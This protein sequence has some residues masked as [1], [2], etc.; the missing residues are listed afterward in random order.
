MFHIEALADRFATVTTDDTTTGRSS[1]SGASGTTSASLL[2]RVKAQEPAAW[3]RLTQVY[4]PFVYRWCRESGL[5][6]ED[7]ADVTQDVFCAVV[8]GIE[9]F[10]GER[11]RGSFRAWL[12][13]ITR[14]KISDLFRR[15]R[16]QPAAQGGTA[17]QERLL[18]IPDEPE[19]LSQSDSVE[20]ESALWRRALACVQT[21]FEDHTCRAFWRVAVDE[22]SPADV[23][24]ELEMTVDA[25]Y[26]A[27]SRVLRRIRQELS[28]LEEP[29]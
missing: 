1:A 11:P 12:R 26:Q 2:R 19:P 15:R 24:A 28:D 7:A 22:Q 20:A 29:S 23:A 16:G 10:R 8:N 13:T 21:E 17:A 9:D 25:V 4:G 14:N 18:Q 6:G 5:T 3:R 27:K